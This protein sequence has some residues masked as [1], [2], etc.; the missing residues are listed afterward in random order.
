MNNYTKIINQ[1][2]EKIVTF[3]K[4]FNCKSKFQIYFKTG[5]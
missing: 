2:K 5:I 1:M 4:K 3:S